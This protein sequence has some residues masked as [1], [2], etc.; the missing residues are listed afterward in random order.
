MKSGEEEEELNW[1]ER[2]RSKG[3][4]V[5][6]EDMDVEKA[7]AGIRRK[8]ALTTHLYTKTSKVAGAV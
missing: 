7:V 3:R 8:C 4:Q 5:P 6:V 1:K 2:T